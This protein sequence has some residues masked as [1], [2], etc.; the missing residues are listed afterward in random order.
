MVNSKAKNK[1]QNK[2]KKE[3]YA[4]YP[5]PPFPKQEQ[6]YPG[7]EADMQPLADHG[8]LSYKGSGKLNGPCHDLIG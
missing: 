1:Q 3:P 7:R 6:K 8:Q 5:I 4:N 2:E